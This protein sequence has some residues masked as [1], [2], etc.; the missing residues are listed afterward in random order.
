MR[1]SWIAFA[2]VLT[3]ASS[4]LAQSSDAPT[5]QS[6]SDARRAEIRQEVLAERNRAI[7]NEY[8]SGLEVSIERMTQLHAAAT[9]F[10]KRLDALAADADGKK[11]AGKASVV[12]E[13]VPL[14]SAPLVD[15][16]LVETRRQNLQ[17]TLDS[18]RG[19]LKEPQV[20]YVPDATQLDTMA[21][22]RDWAQRQIALL[23][24]RTAWLDAEL[25]SAAPPADPASAVTLKDAI[26][27][28]RASEAEMLRTLQEQGRQNVKEQSDRTVAQAAATAELERAAATAQRLLAEARQ[29]QE[30]M[31]LEFDTRMKQIE[32]EAR[33]KWTQ[34]Q[35][36]YE[37]QIS[38]L[39]NELELARAERQKQD[40]QAKT[41][42]DQVNLDAKKIELTAKCK[43]AEV[44]ELLAPFLAEGYT[45][46]GEKTAGFDLKPISLKRLR[47]FG[48]LEPTDDGLLKLIALAGT[49]FDTKRPRWP[50]KGSLQKIEKNNPGAIERIKKAQG[51]LNELGETLVELKMLS[52]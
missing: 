2:A 37:D 12:R 34:D 13:L 45:Q 32:A 5:E 31:R 52:E 14:Y 40:A 50:Y 51:L 24:E 35:K 41:K 49:N 33:S 18:T 48:A 36:R 44:R 26:V 11:L 6:L 29:Q 28:Y 25:A 43:T 21:I 15:A 22:H 42:I 19:Y 38:S 8:A 9:K 47:S 17:R 39:R 3:F 16:A 30:V 27:R 23:V 20:G 4:A 1:R 10:S 46:P 7:L